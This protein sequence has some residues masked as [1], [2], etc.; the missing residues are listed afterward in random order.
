MRK[1]NDESPQGAVSVSGELR[2]EAVPPG[3]G[4]TQGIAR[5]W[6]DWPGE[7]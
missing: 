6:H 7:F 1:M 2:Q 5:E 3:T 4:V